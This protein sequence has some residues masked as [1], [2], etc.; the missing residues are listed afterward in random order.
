MPA[1]LGGRWAFLGGDGVDGCKHKCTNTRGE[2]LSWEIQ[3]SPVSLCLCLSLRRS[4]RRSPR[5][6]V[7]CPRGSLQNYYAPAQQ[8]QTEGN[9]AI[10]NRN[11]T[12]NSSATTMT[13]TT[14]VLIT[15]RTTRTTT[16]LAYQLTNAMR[17][18]KCKIPARLQA[19]GYENGVALGGS[20]GGA[21]QASTVRL[22]RGEHTHTRG[23]TG[24][25]KVRALQKS[26]PKY[27]L[28]IFFQLVLF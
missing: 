8:C 9:Q 3:T 24:R 19:K 16:G 28:K 2:R 5:H 11:R 6:I 27:A 20:V 4:C 10:P 18:C 1:P 22:S 15:A 13:T 17:N 12:R 23:N 26:S 14:T 25:Q 7:E 21:R